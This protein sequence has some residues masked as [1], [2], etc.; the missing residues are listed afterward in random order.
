[1]LDQNDAAPLGPSSVLDIDGREPGLNIGP[2][3]FHP[4]PTRFCAVSRCDGAVDLMLSREEYPY[5]DPAH[6]LE[7]PYMY[8]RWVCQRDKTHFA[9]VSA[10]ECRRSN[11]SLENEPSKCRR[12]AVRWVFSAQSCGRSSYSRFLCCVRSW[13]RLL[14]CSVGF[15]IDCEDHVENGLERWQTISLSGKL[16]PGT[17]RSQGAAER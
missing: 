10:D 16:Q 3:R 5:G 1:M 13:S 12:S 7:W 4:C 2:G 15:A 11:S 8:R 14:G 9:N 17:A 6:M